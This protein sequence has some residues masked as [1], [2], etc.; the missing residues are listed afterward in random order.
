MLTGRDSDP[1]HL[2]TLRGRT[3]GKG[4][5]CKHLICEGAKKGNGFLWKPHGVS[6]REGEQNRNTLDHLQDDLFHLTS[7]PN[8]ES[9]CPT[10]YPETGLKQKFTNS[11]QTFWFQDPSILLQII[12]DPKELLLMWI[13][14]VKAYLLE[15]KTEK[16]V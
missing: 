16:N 6:L 8:V 9:W 3:W 4:R 7:I 11:S 15:I 2:H 5:P 10:T 13:I 1:F 12:E 14:F